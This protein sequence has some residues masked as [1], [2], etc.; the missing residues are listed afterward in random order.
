[1]SDLD[2][3][4]VGLVLD[5]LIEKANDNYEYEQESREATQADFDSF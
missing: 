4:T 5:M 3:L 1:M 2:Q